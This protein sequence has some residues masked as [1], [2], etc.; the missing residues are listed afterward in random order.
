MPNHQDAKKRYRQSLNRRARNRHYRNTVRSRV[1]DVR[2]AAE[3]G[4]VKA[5]TEALNKAVPIIAKVAS[6]GILK[7]R[8]AAR[9][10][11]R[12]T[13][14]AIAPP[15]LSCISSFKPIR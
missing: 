13:K 14:S 12:L 11:G 7:P 9:L 6:K 1:K 3:A 4:D 15:K 5:A 8:T 2:K 10:I